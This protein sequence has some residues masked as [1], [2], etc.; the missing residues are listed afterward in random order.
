[1]KIFATYEFAVNDDFFILALQK[2]DA[3]EFMICRFD[4]NIRY[5][6]CTLALPEHT[7]PEEIISAEIKENSADWINIWN[8]RCNGEMRIFDN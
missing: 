6:V 2:S 7:H 1:M 8:N 3:I 4:S 5:W